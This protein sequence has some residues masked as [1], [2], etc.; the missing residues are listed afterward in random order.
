MMHY[1]KER[2][3]MTE[4]EYNAAE[5]IRRSDLWM[6]NDS[7]EKFRYRMDH[8]DTEKSPAL[9]FGSAC[10]KYILEREDF[11]NE[12]AIAPNVDKRTKAGKEEWQKFCDE[13]AGKTVISEDDFTVMFDM[14]DRIIECPLATE[15][16]EGQHEVPF[17]WTDPETGEKCK[18]KADCVKQED[19]KYVI[20]DYKTTSSA[21]T[22]IFN[23]EIF[24]YGYHFQA[25]MYSEGLQCA[26][27]LDYR[28]RFVFVA[29]EKKAPYS[30][31]VIEVSD[32]VMEYGSTIYHELLRKYH[33]CN[34]MDLW[35]GYVDDVANETQLPGWLMMGEDEI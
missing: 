32:D 21:Q 18:C 23:R 22:E 1:V 4:Q 20:V 2:R 14:A 33:E 19:G 27:G 34:E 35:P 24:R 15:M 9:L 13:N 26:L 29:Q 31:N 10:H 28:P 30:V 3:K 12:Y 6:M 8:P 16:L 17:F 25:A 7:P 5:G 11:R